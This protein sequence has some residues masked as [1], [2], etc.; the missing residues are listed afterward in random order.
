MAVQMPVR[1]SSIS[2][3]RKCAGMKNSVIQYGSACGE[4]STAPITLETCCVISRLCSKVG[5][6]CSCYAQGSCAVQCRCKQQA[7][8]LNDAIQGVEGQAG[9]WTECVLLVVL[10][11][12]VVQLPANSVLAKG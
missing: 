4:A 9:K 11:V 6:S 1:K 12:D 7:Q 2:N 8:H 3:V 5:C 10:M